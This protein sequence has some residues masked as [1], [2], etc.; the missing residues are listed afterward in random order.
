MKKG[1]RVAWVFLFFLPLL[2]VST[3]RAED[4]AP[5][6]AESVRLAV[7]HARNPEG[8]RPSSLF[9][10][11]P[12]APAPQGLTYDNGD[13]ATGNLIVRSLSRSV[14]HYRYSDDYVGKAD[15]RIYDPKRPQETAAWVT[16]GNDMTKFL[17]AHGA[18]G[19][20][21]VRLMER[22]L[23]MDTSGTHD[24]V[25]EFTVVPD[26][27]HLMRPARNPDITEYTPDEYRDTAEPLKAP[28]MGDSTYENFKAYYNNFKAS[29][30]DVD[31]EKS[32]FP[33][34]QLGY[35]FFWGNGYPLEKIQGL[36]ELI[37]LG[38]TPVGIWGIYATTSYLY[39]RNDGTSF[40][41]ATGDQFGNGFASFRITGTCETVWAGHRF[42]KKV[43]TTAD[44]PNVI[45]VEKGAVVSGG[46][47]ILVWS[48]NYDVDNAG[49]ISGATAAK[50]G[51]AGTA[52]VAV[53]FKGDTTT[54][55]GTPITAG[56]NRL[57]NRG[58][59]SSP[60]TAVKAEG[61]DTVVESR[62]GGVISG[63]EYAVKTGAGN[64]TVTL[65]GGEIDGRVDLG[66]GADRFD[67]TGAEEGVRLGVTLGKETARTPRILVRDAG[68]GVVTI[69]DGTTIA[70]TTAGKGPIV[71]GETFLVVDTDNL[72]VTPANLAV[73]N[74]DALP[75]VRF[76]AAKDGGRLYLV[77]RR[78]GA[79]Y[80][81]NSGNASL[82]A[83]LDSL[84]GTA[85]GTWP[86]S[87]GTWTGRGTPPT[88]GSWGPSPTAPPSWPPSA[89][90]PATPKPSGGGSTNSGRAGE[91]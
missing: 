25:V 5:T 42:Q 89:P 40:S 59:I 87:W 63:G 31:N 61:G 38:G 84:V 66:T 9:V 65:K 13:P 79:Y 56:V 4:L 11:S 64:D 10:V 21:V 17:D 20:N 36:S 6:Y 15:Y 51:L 34:T 81:K 58:T 26:N 80:G 90:W 35:T 50:F 14:N 74:D 12:A 43:R 33:W 62:R 28:G 47:G 70:V 48:L 16:T 73:R 32:R 86:T 22:A 52:D 41:D 23:G 60:G 44:N 27:D 49:V 68:A 88:P 3:I 75:M 29:A 39:T 83:V 2:V 72:T 76:E 82:G 57:V 78:D 46:E 55:H 54:S 19:G 24:V 91:G 18:T 67:V 1:R 7:D 85:G 8:W 30:Y 53:L 37:I 45:V 77:A 69:A 71:N